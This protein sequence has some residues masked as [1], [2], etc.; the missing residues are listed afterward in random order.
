MQA[1]ANEIVYLS[2]VCIAADAAIE[3]PVADRTP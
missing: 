1:I 3:R 2:T